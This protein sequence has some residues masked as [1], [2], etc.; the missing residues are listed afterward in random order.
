MDAHINK[1]FNNPLL[2][3]WYDSKKRFEIKMKGDLFFTKEE[4]ANLVED[5][6]EKLNNKEIT[7]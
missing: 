4:A 5:L 3:F 7:K 1:D 2:V 6:S